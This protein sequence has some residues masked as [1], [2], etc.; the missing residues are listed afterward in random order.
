PCG[1]AAAPS[2]TAARLPITTPGI[3][4]RLASRNGHLSPSTYIHAAT[5]LLLPVF[6]FALA[7]AA[8]W[9]A[10]G[11]LITRWLDYLRRIA[12]AYGRGHYG[13]RPTALAAAPT[14]FKALGETISGMAG[15]IEDC[16]LRLR[17][18]CETTACM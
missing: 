17:G 9:I 15:A 3:S 7:S 11:R 1:D 4:H 6:M 8:I 2:S 12:V 5:D 18:W 13:V 16:D 10:T 14:E